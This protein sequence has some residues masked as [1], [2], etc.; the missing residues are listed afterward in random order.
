MFFQ[1]SLFTNIEP[2][3]LSKITLIFQPT[4]F[5]T[6]SRGFVSSAHSN[7]AEY[8]III[9]LLPALLIPGSYLSS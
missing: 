8:I 3:I 5:P 4:S 2:F 7:K 1:I 6:S 9:S